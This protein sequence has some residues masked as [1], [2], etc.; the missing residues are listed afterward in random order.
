[1]FNTITFSQAQREYD[2]EMPAYYYD[3]DDDFEIEDE[4]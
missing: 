1:M 3:D 4:N 2:N